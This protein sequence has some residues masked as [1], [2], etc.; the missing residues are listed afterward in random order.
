MGSL[1]NRNVWLITGCSSGLGRCIAEA[2]L[3][4][5]DVVVATA[6]NLKGIADLE[7]KGALVRELDV[8]ASEDRIEGVIS[9]ILSVTGKV[10]ILV[11]NAGYILTGAVEEVR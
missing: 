10:D 6:R 11:N 5:G 4:H 3:N 1:A 7:K 2:A 8:T 9:G